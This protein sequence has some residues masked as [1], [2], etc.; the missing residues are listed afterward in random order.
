MVPGYKIT[1]KMAWCGVIAIVIATFAL[2]FFHTNKIC[3]WASAI[4]GI[5]GV[6]DLA[7]AIAFQNKEEDVARSRRECSSCK[8]EKCADR[9]A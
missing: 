8:C 5:L 6:F 2:I 7:L 3:V 4:G 9:K 1:S